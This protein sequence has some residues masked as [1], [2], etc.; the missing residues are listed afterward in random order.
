MNKKVLLI[1]AIFF[2]KHSFAQQFQ[3]IETEAQIGHAVNMN[4]VAVADYDQDGDLDIYFTGIEN[5][6]INNDS[7]WSRLLQN[8]GDGTFE[9]VTIQAGFG[10]QYVNEGLKAERGEKMG[11]AWGDYDNDGFPDLFLANSREDQLYRNNGDGTFEDVTAQA[12]VGGCNVCYSASGTWFDHDRDGDLDLYVSLVNDAN[13]LYENK[14]DGTFEDITRVTG[15]GGDKMITWS[16]VAWDIGKDGYLDIWNIN[17][18]Q[19]NEFFE[20]RSGQHYNEASR[21]YRLDDEGAGMGVAIGD[22]NNDGFFDAFVTNIYSHHPNPLFEN[23]ANRRFLDKA[24]EMGVED[25]GWAWGTHFFD[26]DH[27]GDEDL[28]VVNG[29]IDKLLGQ[30]QEDIDNFFFKNMLIEGAA[31][32]EDESQ[33]S[34]F[35]GTAKGKG[36]EVFDYDMD[37]DLDLLVANMNDA[38]YFFK[39]TTINNSQPTAQNWFQLDLEGVVSNRN[40]FGTEVRII[41]GE[42]SY[43][44]FHHG[45]GIFG[46]SIKPLHFGIG[47]ATMIDEIQISWLTGK[48]E[49]I[50]NVSANQVLHF[51]EGSGTEIERVLPP[52]SKGGAAIVE[53][54]FA[55]PNPFF[56]STTLRFEL[57]SIGN[58]DVS[59][60]SFLGKEIFHFNQMVDEPGVIDIPLDTQ[61]LPAGTY[62]YRAKIKDKEKIGKMMK[63]SREE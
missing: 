30:G 15:V 62:Y 19:I 14:G 9:D 41:I 23:T 12:G 48:T 45:A 51:S 57:A 46:Q 49:A 7:T 59:I 20:N 10:I 39:N 53:K 38:P 35:V 61:H 11:A 25:T 27:D 60:Y 54:D 4:G 6:D 40:A 28:A 44:R 50:Y 32:F 33:S 58:L 17:D 2:L 22:Y 13:I 5:F 21:A 29:P 43:Y 31:T 24:A 3:R 63:I 26:Y 55:F 47:E 52:K 34:G 16:T 1:L 8:Q 56:E 37:G 36:L 42:K 18:T